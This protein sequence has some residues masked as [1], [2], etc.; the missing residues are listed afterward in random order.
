MTSQSRQIGMNYN[1]L[2]PSSWEDRKIEKYRINLFR[3][4]SKMF[5]IVMAYK[6]LLIS[7]SIKKGLMDNIGLSVIRDAK[8]V[9]ETN[10]DTTFEGCLNDAENFD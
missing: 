10:L 2:V 3:F 8:S 5:S 1:V 6:P 7:I 9:G 4:I